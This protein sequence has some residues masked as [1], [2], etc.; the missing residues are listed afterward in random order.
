[1]KLRLLDNRLNRELRDRLPTSVANA[2]KRLLGLTP[3][4]GNLQ[5]LRPFSDNY[6]S[7]RGTPVDRAYIEEFLA[8][9]ATDIRGEVLEVKEPEFA[10]RLGDR[11]VTRVHVVDIRRDNEQATIVADLCEPR[12][13][14]AAQFDCFILTQTLHLLPD[15]DAALANAWQTLAE[16][17]VLLLSVPTIS[18]ID[19]VES[20]F[21]RFTPSG[22][23]KLL[24]AAF[25]DASVEVAGYGNVVAA[26]S[27][28]LGLAAH[29]VAPSK[30]RAVDRFFPIVA[31]A[32]VE[33]RSRGG[34]SVAVDGV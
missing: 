30:L 22:L 32:R 1:M 28:I 10:Q 16:N 7:D 17:G 18:R 8:S 24:R 5:R 19:P 6:G 9:H 14:P 15:V 26:L 34:G 3:R 29:E 12:S 33:K 4:W 23:E 2:A 21:W 31:C 25:P 20:D 13:L 11:R 27:A